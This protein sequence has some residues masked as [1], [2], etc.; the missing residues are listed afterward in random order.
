ML[1]D[2]SANGASFSGRIERRLLSCLVVH[3]F[4][5]VDPDFVI[6]AVWGEATPKS[7]GA[8]IESHMSR[9][10]KALGR[11]TIRWTG[12]AYAVE[13]TWNESV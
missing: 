1:G 5:L 2:L 4:H 8:A 11:E 12:W 9:L 10:R 7:P 3:R 6:D 13:L